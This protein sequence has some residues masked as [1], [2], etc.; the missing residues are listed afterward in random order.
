MNTRDPEVKMQI[1]EQF[2]GEF[3]VTK[4][5]LVDEYVEPG[6]FILDTWQGYD[7]A[8]QRSPKIFK[9]MIS[10]LAERYREAPS[11]EHLRIYNRI[12]L[13]SDLEL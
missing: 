13:E 2:M 10:K 3:G 9:T 4:Y 5:E 7:F 12:Q 6:R 8:I 1:A 11:R